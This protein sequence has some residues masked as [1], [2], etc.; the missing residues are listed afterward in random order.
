MI[1]Y[2]LLSTVAALA[3]L[4]TVAAPASAEPFKCA[5]TGGNFTFGQEA[6]INGLDQMTSGTIST[7]NIAMN[8]FESLMTRDENFSPILE[9][10][11]SMNESSDHL[12][13]TFKL[14]QG[15][16]FHN[17]KEMTSADVVASFDRYAKIGLYRSSIA[18]VDRWD[19]PDKNTFVIYLKKPQPTFLEIL[20]SFSAPIV[21]VPAEDKDDPP[22]QLKSIGTG[23]WQLVES[24][25]GGYV[26]LKR[27]ERYKPN[28]NFD[29]KTGFGGY[30]QAC[31]DNVTFRIV[32]EPQARVAG[33]KTGE[34]QGVED[35]PTKSLPDLKADKNI[36]LIPL[37]N[38]WIQIAQPNV[39]APPTDNLMFRKAV[40][41]VLD[42]D[43]IMDAASDGNYRLN[44]GFQYPNQAFYSDAGKETYNIKNPELAKKYL[45]ESG[46]K[47]EPVVLL[48]DKDYPAMYNS[49]LVM[50]QEMQAIG[51]NAQLKVVDWPTSAQMALKPDTGWNL[52]YTGWG[53]QPALGALATMQFF[54]QP[55]A[56]YMPKGGQ[57]DPQVLALWN[58]MNSLPTVEGRKEAFAK[59]QK[60]VLEQVYTLPLGSLTKVQA[61]RSNVKGFVPYRI[62]RVSNVWFTN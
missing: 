38:W 26:K 41:A 59:M 3:G 29:Q 5:H 61:V 39:S 44:V 57:D 18:N 24:V 53:T 19:A 34:L 30:K 48:T 12:T 52:F 6:N 14:R 10:A 28:T 23:P 22:M 32:T 13:Y 2:A 40:Q 45:A 37:Q 36:T 21:I 27:Y 8:I 15:I 51:I 46:Y 17:G 47:G 43:E 60:Y 1:R 58:D 7:R 50:Q 25:P 54:V 16:H 62:P 49:A 9:L 11:D 56:V 31:F 42:M 4:A 33:L 55:G 20:S 35:L